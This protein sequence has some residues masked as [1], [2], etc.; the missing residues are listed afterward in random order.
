M[1]R[2][3][4][5]LIAF[6]LACPHALATDRPDATGLARPPVAVRALHAQPVSGFMPD[7]A[8]GPA[9]PA[10]PLRI[11]DQAWRT[12]DAGDVAWIDQVPLSDGDSV[13]LRLTR[14]DPYARDARI[15]VMEA[16]AD[17]RP[18]ERQ[19]ALPAVSAWSGT[20][21]GRPG[22]RAFIAR[23]AAGLQGYI[24]FDGRTEIISS[25]PEGAGGT[26]MIADAA[27][28]PTGDFTCGG[29]IP[30]PDLDDAPMPGASRAPLTAACRQLP[31]AFETDQEL[32][33]KFSGNTTTASAYVA[34]LVAALMDIYSRDFNVRPSICYLR[35]WASTD[36]WTQSGTCGG[37]GSDQLGELRG[38]WNANMQSV[39]RALT[40]MLSGRNLGGGCAW[41]WAT[42]ENPYDGYGYS[43]SANLAGSF[44]YPI[45]NQSG[46][47][48]DL[49]VVAHEIGHNLSC[50]HT[51]DVGV[52]GCG[53]GDCSLARQG[54]IMSYCHLCAGGTSNINMNFDPVNIPQVQDFLGNYASCTFPEYADPVAVGDTY[55][56]W[57]GTPSVL[58]VLANDLPANCEAVSIENL[59]ATSALGV[60][61]TVLP[62]GGV[63]GGP[64]IS[65][66]PGPGVRGA[67][68]FSYRLRDS[69]DQLST[70]ATVSIDVKPILASTMGLAGNESGLRGRYYGLTNPLSLPDFDALTP[71]QFLNVPL[72]SFG[73]TLATCLGSARSDNFGVVFEGWL[74]A[75]S[76][77][78]YTFSLTSDAGSRLFIDGFRVI[79]H[80]G[81]HTFSEKTGTV[82]LKA[83]VHSLRVP[84]F[85]YTG[86]CGLQLKW[87]PP[88]TTTRVFVPATALSH[89][90]Q[91][92][93]LDGS[94]SVD[95][96]DLSVLLLGFGGECTGQRCYGD[97]NDRQYIGFEPA[98]SC[99][100]DLDGSG[101]IDFGDVALL[102]LY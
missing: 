55:S 65:Y 23:S 85:E 72:L 101:E 56:M 41:L 73:S 100:E 98:C 16:G 11:D 81:I 54:T 6:L 30:R 94:G 13:D 63:G 78:N 71:Y 29:G 77:G 43:V 75:P 15:V 22:S 31:L 7:G 20:V 67:D 52:D 21:A 74:L 35:W 48:W 50:Y 102:L 70:L 90:G 64:A 8:A 27:S 28:L 62:T 93:D 68:S 14:L 82:Y 84:F 19:I 42:C 96:G 26:P 10:M 38:W 57:E 87:A 25:G 36:P 12:I 86:A 17:G 88:G 47:N 61:L 91:V 89:G 32:L 1:P 34:T 99:P 46:A 80:D 18:V 97:P 40:A 66:S 9:Y 59:P 4:A 69:S 53:N 45:V 24:Q 5:T 83:G 92:Y 2:L 33:A 44:P 3:P 95:A 58:D 37:S 39:P 60:P 76:E 51:H 79:D 49:I